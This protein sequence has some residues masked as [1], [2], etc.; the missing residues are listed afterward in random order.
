MKDKAKRILDSAMD[1]IVKSSSIGKL[2][3]KKSLMERER[4]QFFQH[5]GELTYSLYKAGMLKDESL[6]DL[7]DDIN[8]INNKIRNISEN[9]EQYIAKEKKEDD[10]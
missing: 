8:N 4:R 6:Q 1:M 5:L 10:K 2:M 9:L 7:V 3:M